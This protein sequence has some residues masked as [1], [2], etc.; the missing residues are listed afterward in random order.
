VMPPLAGR[1]IEE[2]CKQLRTR[3]VLFGISCGNDWRGVR[4]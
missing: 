4:A 2:A 3:R 1:K